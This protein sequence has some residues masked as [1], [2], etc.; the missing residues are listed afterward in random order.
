MPLDMSMVR[1]LGFAAAGASPSRSTGEARQT[2]LARRDSSA[3]VG[4]LL[5]RLPL[6]A[7]VGRRPPDKP[8]ADHAS[9]GGP[10]P[11]RAVRRDRRLHR[12]APLST[13]ARAG[14]TLARATALSRRAGSDRDHGAE[15]VEPPA[16]GP[17]IPSLRPCERRL[18]D[19]KS[20]RLNSV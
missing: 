20:T 19:R 5:D 14:A 11:R 8:P 2:T 7:G 12:Q 3:A 15:G 13:R 4:A 16:V 10:G 18:Q 9:R 6:V 1:S 17:A